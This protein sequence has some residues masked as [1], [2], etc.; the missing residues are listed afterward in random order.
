MTS[1]TEFQSLTTLIKR[2]EAATSRL[3]DL[4]TSGA[5]VVAVGTN[6]SRNSLGSQPAVPSSLVS[7][8]IIDPTAEIELPP[9]LSAYDELIEGPLETFVELSKSIGGLVE[10][11]SH[12]VEDI[13]IAQ[14]DF[15]DVAIKSI[16]PDTRT[17]AELIKPTLQALEK[18]CEYRE[19]N[20]PSPFF[21]HLSTVGEGIGALGWVTVESKTAP[22]VGD[23]KESSQFYANRVIKEFKDKDRTHVDWANSFVVLLTELQ[24]YV[25]NY[26]TTGLVWNPQA[27]MSSVFAD[28]NRGEGIVNTLKKVDKSQ[29]THKN[30]SLRA[31]STVSEGQQKKGPAAP[32]KPAAL[33]LKKQPKTELNGTKWIIEHYE[34]NSKLVISDT[35]INQTVYIFGCKN[36]TIQVKGKVNAVILGELY[37]CQ[38]TDLLLDSAVAAIDIVNSKSVQLQIQ[39]HTPTIMIDKTDIG[40]IYLSS[41]CL[42]TEILTA[43]SSSINVNVPGVGEN[44][45]YAERPIP[46]QFKSTIVDGR[47]VSV[48]VEHTG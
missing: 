35:A 9:A 33:S 26:H 21:N 37:T 22:Y 45:D 18:V 40:Q 16:K 44:G 29:M 12:A 39:G 30:P 15:L 42:K 14:R 27:D 41:E 13:F 46:E 34:N 43:K 24:N 48:P 5:T 23:L 7:P 1:M 38:K 3:E 28:L 19:N 31:G 17:F 10:D 20:R 8:P 36:S 25:K 2:L 6:I 4:A 32:P 47:L 11:Q